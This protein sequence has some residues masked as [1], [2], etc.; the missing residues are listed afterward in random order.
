MSRTTN[1]IEDRLR[2]ALDARA[3]Q[4]TPASLRPAEPPAVKRP[5]RII[6][7]APILAAAAVLAVLGL[8][9]LIDRGGQGT[10]PPANPP[11]VV[12][13]SGTCDRE[14][15]LISKALDTGGVAADV[16]GD[17]AADRVATATDGKAAPKCRAFVGVRT[18][19]GATYSTVL[20]GQVVP[21]P[22]MEAEVI[23]V[24]DLGM[25][26]RADI[27]VNTHFTADSAVSQLFTWTDDGL[28][29]VEAPAFEDGNVPV[30]GGGVTSPQAAGCTD[31][32]SLVISMAS[33]LGKGDSYQVTRQVYPV[34]GEPITFG[35]PRM[36]T[37]K[38]PAGQLI[39]R[40]PEYGSDRF[41]PCTHD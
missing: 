31:D 37:D 22:G 4:V 40:F 7:G 12:Q 8:V 34:H 23:G 20:A 41:V 29:R 38:V 18:A 35:S 39:Q 28:V 6:W 27:L 2:R 14:E 32:G 21:P 10:T 15:A 13:T 19:T 36:P 1:D 5:W 24:P 16:D 9:S 26:G 3:E 30:E 17:G 33:L 11:T 25:D